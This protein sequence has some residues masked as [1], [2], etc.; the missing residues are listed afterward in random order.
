[1]AVVSVLFVALNETHRLSLRTALDH[2][3]A[4]PKDVHV[5]QGWGPCTRGGCVHPEQSYH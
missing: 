1:M 3:D 2:Q 5:Q 4:G